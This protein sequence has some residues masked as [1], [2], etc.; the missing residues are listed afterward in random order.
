MADKGVGDRTIAEIDNEAIEKF[1]RQ[2]QQS[3]EREAKL[4]R[5]YEWRGNKLP[6]FNIEHMPYERQRLSGA[7][8][9]S[10]DRALRRQWLKDQ[11]LSPNEP[12]HVSELYPKNPIRRA[13]SA[14]WETLFK[15]LRPVL[16]GRTFKKLN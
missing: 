16:V 7:G 3:M 5:Q 10:E 6:P 13:F 9:T 8:M 14:P 12:R 1:N 11:E 4:L 2:L 15:A